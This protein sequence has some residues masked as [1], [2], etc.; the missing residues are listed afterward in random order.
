MESRCRALDVSFV[1]KARM[2]SLNFSPSEIRFFPGAPDLAVEILSPNNTRREINERLADFFASGCQIAWVIDPVQEC[3]EICH[4]LTQRRLLGP[5]GDLE[6]EDLL[7]GFRYRIADLF[8][9]WEW[10]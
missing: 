9:Q 3:A 5:G 2:E 6:G 7:P 1:T 8:K 10:D 4:S